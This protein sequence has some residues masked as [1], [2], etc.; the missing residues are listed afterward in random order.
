MNKDEALR[1]SYEQ[2]PYTLSPHELSNP[3]RFSVVARLFSLHCARVTT[4]RVL[5]LGCAAG[6]NLVPLAYSHPHAEFVGVDLADSHISR[7]KADAK[8]LALSNV[9]FIQSDFR[10]LAASLGDFD[11][12]IAHGIHSWISRDAQHQLLDFIARSLRPDGV[13]Y[14]SYNTYPG[15]SQHQPLRALLHFHVKPESGPAEILKASHEAVKFVSEAIPEQDGS[16]AGNWRDLQDLLGRTPG[17]QLLHDHLEVYNNPVYFYE[18]AGQAAQA[19][20]RYVGDAAIGSMHPSDLSAESRAELERHAGGKLVRTEQYLDFIRNRS[21]RQSLLCHKARQP[22][23]KVSP[24]SI[25]P[26]S[27]ASQLKCEAAAPNFAEGAATNY[28]LPAN[29]AKV[30]LTLSSELGKRVLHALEKAWP[31]SLAFHDL[32]AQTKAG[33]SKGSRPELEEEVAAFVFELMLRSAV[34]VLTAAPKLQPELSVAPKPF[35]PGKLYATDGALTVNAYHQS[36]LLNPFNRSVLLAL[37]GAKSLDRIAGELTGKITP[38]AGSLNDAVRDAAQKLH[39][40][41]LI[42]G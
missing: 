33:Y 23:R 38:P 22:I 31:A 14:V 34:V 25:Q 4:A 30:T 7:A 32:T 24:A 29:R 1:Q 11:Y 19:G 17:A 16:F 40:Y 36:V 26:F 3:A 28:V 39:S 6:G 12:I 8:R 21:F 35:A 27:F 13:A 41:A 37:D 10:S 42:E 18:F 15:W 2:V 20:L 9:T 5:E